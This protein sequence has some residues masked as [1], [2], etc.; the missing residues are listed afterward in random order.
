VA[1]PSIS[2]EPIKEQKI[3]IPFKNRQPALDEQKRIVSYLDQISEKQKTLLKIY[4][5][6]DNQITQLKQSILTKAFRGQ[7][8]KQN[9]NNDL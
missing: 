1:Q 2:Q 8:G 6:I 3:P 5:D 9:F 7:L 4:A